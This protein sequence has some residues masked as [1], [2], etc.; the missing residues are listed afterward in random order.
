MRPG[1]VLLQSVIPVL[2]EKGNHSWPQH[3]VNI[4]LCCDAIASSWADVLKDDGS[5]D[6]IKADAAPYHHTRASPAIP[7]Q[8]VVGSISVVVSPPDPD[9]AVSVADTKPTLISE[10]NVLP[11]SPGPV[12]VLLCE[13]QP[14]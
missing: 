9:A 3:L 13:L 10:Q 14:G 8:D 1:V 7:L 4:A 11:L 2:V 6:F 5:Q 12:Q